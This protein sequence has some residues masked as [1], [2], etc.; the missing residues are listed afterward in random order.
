[1]NDSTPG[2]TIFLRVV[3]A[4][5]AVFGILLIRFVTRDGVLAARK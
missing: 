4:S 1:M 3:L 2:D 5:C